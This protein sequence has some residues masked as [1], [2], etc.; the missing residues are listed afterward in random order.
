VSAEKGGTIDYRESIGPQAEL[1]QTRTLALAASESST[2]QLVARVGRIDEW[3]RRGKGLSG[4]VGSAR[5][6]WKK[7]GK[8]I[9]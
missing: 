6:R 1:S 9:R 2:G 4:L 7:A 5:P 8:T 3:V